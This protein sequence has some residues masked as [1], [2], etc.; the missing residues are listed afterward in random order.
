MFTPWFFNTVFGA[1][2]GHIKSLGKLREQFGTTLG[3]E[4]NN[5]RTWKNWRIC[6]LKKENECLNLVYP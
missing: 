5:T 3:Q 4:M 1:G 6:C 2:D